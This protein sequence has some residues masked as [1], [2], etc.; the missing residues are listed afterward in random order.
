MKKIILAA[1]ALLLL[2]GCSTQETVETSA[3]PLTLALETTEVEADAKGLAT[4]TGTGTP[5]MR[6]FVGESFF[7]DVARVDENGDFTATYEIKGKEPETIPIRLKNMDTQEEITTDVTIV[8]NQ[9]A[10][11]DQEEAADIRNLNETV[12]HGQREILRQLMTQAFKQDYPYKG[13]KV[14]TALGVI[15]DW[16]TVD[17][18]WFYKAEATIVNEFGAEQEVTLEATITPTDASNGEVTLTVY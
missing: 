5:D 11:K 14:H 10:L 6:V 12:T 13:S 1:T 4:I 17:K 9:Q 15:Q 18:A 7:G 2:T 3:A 16:T 8:P